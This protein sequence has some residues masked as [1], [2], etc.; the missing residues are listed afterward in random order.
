M[1]AEEQRLTDLRAHADNAEFREMADAF[2]ARVQDL[3]QQQDAKARALATRDDAARRSFFSAAQPVLAEILREAGAALILER[4]NV[5]LSANAIDITD[6]AIAR[7]NAQIGDGSDLPAPAP[8]PTSEPA[9]D[10]SA[11]GP[12]EE[13]PDATT[14]PAR[15]GQGTG[16]GLFDMGNPTGSDADPDR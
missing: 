16:G 5:L 1:T 15:D 10:A 8:E 7:V 12:A 11:G 13:A 6:L 3:R 14:D 9:E 4:A 2:D